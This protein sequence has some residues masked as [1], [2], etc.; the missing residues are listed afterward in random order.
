MLVLPDLS[1]DDEPEMSTRPDV[2][3]TSRDKGEDMDVESTSIK[4]RIRGLH[5]AAWNSNPRSKKGKGAAEKPRVS[6]NKLPKVPL[7]QSPRSSEDKKAIAVGGSPMRGW[8]LVI[9]TTDLRC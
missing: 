6:I 5:S 8:I 3:E 4:D 1:M 7:T 9:R 2:S